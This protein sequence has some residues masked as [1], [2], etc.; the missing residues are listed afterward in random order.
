MEIRL[1]KIEDEKSVLKLLDE[2]GEELNNKTIYSEHNIEAQKIGGPIF[3]EIISR[4]DTYIFVAV[5][6]EEIVG[7]VTFYLLPNIR[8]GMHRGHIEYFVV[9]KNMRGK[10]V[11]TKLFD[12]IKNFC[13]KSNIKVI[14]LDTNNDLEAH[15]FYSKNGGK[16]TEVMYRFDID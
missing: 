8:H 14:K 10:G 3:K 9:S 5:E 4:E 7:L 11:G 1:A 13:R 15:S 12:A 16:Q 2:L 6:N